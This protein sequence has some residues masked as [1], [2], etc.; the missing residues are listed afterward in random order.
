MTLPPALPRNAALFLDFDGC[1]VEIAPRPDLVDLPPAL[2]GRLV[3]LYEHLDRALALVSGRDV[4]DLRRWLPEFPGII[5]G[6]HGAELSMQRDVI[7]TVH[8][9][10]MDIAGLHAAAFDLASVQ[11][12]VLVEPKPHGVTLHYREDPSLQGFV[13]GVMARLLQDFDGLELQPAK[14]ALELRPFGI[15]KGGAI[16]RLTEIE[17][18]KGRVPVYVGDDLTDEPA[19]A[20]AQDRGGFAIKIG[21][22]DTQARYRLNGPADLA[23]WL[24][25]ALANATPAGQTG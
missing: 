25:A 18:F 1:L 21:E 17:P 19:M 24:D 20:E 8:E 23:A 15:G 9:S 16:A 10:P 6:S 2:P 5:A 14:M 12:S 7:D 3:R 11:P 22:G 13:A 4:A